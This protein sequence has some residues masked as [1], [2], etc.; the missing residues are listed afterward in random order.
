MG[1]Q[2]QQPELRRSETS[3]TVQDSA[4]IK[5]D[6]RNFD[7]DKHPTPPGNR[8]GWMDTEEHPAVTDQDKPDHAPG[9]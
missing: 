2:P 8:P 4:K 3:S 1:R 5:A 6:N 7:R 9:E